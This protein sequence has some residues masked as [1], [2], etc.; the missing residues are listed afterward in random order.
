ML[1][2]PERH[3]PAPEQ[4]DEDGDDEESRDTAPAHWPGT[5]TPSAAS[6]SSASRRMRSS[7]SAVR[8]SKRR[9]SMGW[10]FEALISP[11]VREALLA[12]GVQR[13]AFSD[14]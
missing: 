8:A 1:G 3:P 12:S 11:A 5:L 2:V 6:T 4:R 13:I 7:P 10:V 9:T 14:L